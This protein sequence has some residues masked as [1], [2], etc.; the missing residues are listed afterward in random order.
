VVPWVR[1]LAGVPQLAQEAG[2]EPVE[3]LAPR[4]RVEPGVEEAAFEGGPDLAGE[5]DG[6]VVG[7]HRADVEAAERL[8]VD[9]GGVGEARGREL[10][11]VG[12]EERAQLGV[13]GGARE[14]LGLEVRRGE[15]GHAQLA[16]R[17]PQHLGHPRL[18]GQR[19]EVRGDRPREVEKEP[20][21]QRRPQPVGGGLDARLDEEGRGHPEGQLERRR[22]SAVVRS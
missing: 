22:D 10:A 1:P 18:L 13:F 9:A 7:A 6:H 19:P 8:L 11:F 14:G 17:G 4:Q 21:D 20:R 15:P 5:L 12:G 2:V 3:D 16:D